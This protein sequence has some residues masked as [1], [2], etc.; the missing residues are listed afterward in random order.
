MREAEPKNGTA[1]GAYTEDSRAPSTAV[2]TEAQSELSHVIIDCSSM[3][4]IDLMG[5]NALIQLHQEFKDV[6]I[7][8]FYCSFSGERQKCISV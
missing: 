3:P 1:N 4:Y 8:V 2:L 6:E 7:T 5:A